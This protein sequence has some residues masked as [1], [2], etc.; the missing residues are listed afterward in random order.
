[1]PVAQG[2][3]AEFASPGFTITVANNTVSVFRATVTDLAGN[4]SNCSTAR[5][6]IED[7]TPPATPQITDTDPNSPANDNS[8]QV[9]G[10]AGGQTVKLYKSTCAGTPVAQGSSTQFAS[11]GFLA[12]VPNNVSTNF[13]ATATDAAGNVSGCSAPLTYRE[14][15]MPPPVASAHGH[16]PGVAGQ[17]QHGHDHWD[18][19][20]VHPEAVRERRLHRRP[21]GA[22]PLDPVASP[23]YTLTVADNTATAFRATATDL[24]GNTSACSSALA[25]AEDSAPPAAPQLTD[26]DP[27]SP[28]N[29]NSPRLKGS[30][31]AG[32]TV[33]L[34]ESSDCTGAA[35][36]Q[37]SAGAFAAPGLLA[38][39]T[40]DA[41]ATFTA[42]ATDAAG[43]TSSCSSSFNYQEDST[44]PDTQIDSGPSG[45]TGDS[46]PSFTFSANE[47]GSSFQCRFDSNPFA[48]CSGPGQSHT[49]AERAF[50]R[51]P[52]VRGPRHRP[53][54]EHR[55]DTCVGRVHGRHPGP[56]R[57]HDHR[58]RPRLAC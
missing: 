47:P 41:V 44:P 55:P 51:R 57:A 6:Y 53:S 26:S 49:A 25:Y 2:T 11:P 12:A 58:H 7:S 5:P 38:S 29:D 50:R 4:V 9:K 24:A 19:R 10:T 52:Y 33:H 14:D 39:V 34:Y 13:R 17:R 54:P 22:G 56:R 35:E 30:A 18:G 32:S 40:S 31:E 42:T 15:S 8:L 43:N 48:A 37:G 46:T 3:T 1:M 20:R 27:N 16:K 36:A 45:L 23:G 28:A 21:G